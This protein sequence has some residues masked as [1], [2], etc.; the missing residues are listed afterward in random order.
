MAISPVP[1]RN[2]R[3]RIMRVLWVFL[4][5]VSFCALAPS[6][7]SA[8]WVYDW[9]TA[10]ATSVGV[11][12]DQEGVPSDNNDNWVNLGGDG[13]GDSDV[14]RNA[15][16]PAF[17]SGNYYQSTGVPADDDL[18]HRP[19]DGNFSYSIPSDARSVT[20]SYLLDTFLGGGA[21]RMGL[22]DMDVANAINFGLF[23]G[24]GDWGVREPDGTVITILASGAAA[25]DSTRRTYRATVTIDLT[26]VG[27]DKLLDMVVENLSDGGSETIFS[28]LSYDLGPV[29]DPSQ[30]DGL[31]LRI[32]NNTQTGT[33]A[34]TLTISYIPIPEPATLSLVGLGAL[35]LIVRRKRRS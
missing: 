17:F 4:A 34:D 33:S 7:A 24:I 18:Y 27:P 28:G 10:N 5:A 25:L 14:V 20:A 32:S 19:N 1:P 12:L 35:G 11:V 13:N 8:V 6:V 3:V 30:W 31:Y 22:K 2:E 26:P 23:P 15:A 9:S 21:H 16:Q 29:T